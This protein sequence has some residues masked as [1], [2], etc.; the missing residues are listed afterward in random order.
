VTQKRE[1]S[2]QLELLESHL[3]YVF[4]NPSLGI[5]ALSH[6]SLNSER[7]LAREEMAEHNEQL[8]F[9]G[10]AVLGLLVSEYLYQQYSDLPEGQLSIHKARIVSAAHLVE[11]ARAIQLGECLILGR[12]EELSGG[13]EKKALLADGLEAVLAAVYLDG[14][15]DAARGVI[16]RTILSLPNATDAGH[17]FHNYKATLQ[18]LAQANGL[19][20]PIYVTVSTDGPEH[21]KRFTVEARVGLEWAETGEGDT[22]KAAGQIAARLLCERLSNA[23][24][25]QHSLQVADVKS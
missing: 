20:Q 3:G 6:R 19:P 11:A 10:D 18:E 7:R 21:A 22:K 25:G 15:L 8:E 12:G 1:V 16:H 23:R 9:L 2:E 24:L 14:G 17:D 5:R 4:R 13:R